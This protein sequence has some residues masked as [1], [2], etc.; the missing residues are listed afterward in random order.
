MDTDA[1]GMAVLVVQW[2]CVTYKDVVLVPLRTSRRTAQAS[3]PGDYGDV[4]RTLNQ[5]LA[6]FANEVA[7]TLSSALPAARPKI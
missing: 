2:E 6:D 3:R 7:T 1:A 4:V 5:T